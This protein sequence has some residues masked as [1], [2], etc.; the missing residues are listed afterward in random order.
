MSQRRTKR[1]WKRLVVEELSRGKLAVGLG[2]LGLDHKRG[3]QDVR[4]ESVGGKLGK[5]WPDESP[6]KEEL[7]VLQVSKNLH[8]PGMM[9][10]KAIKAELADDW[11]KLTR[12]EG[13]NP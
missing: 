6:H 11:S 5:V 4:E 7:A 13:L 12:S 1:Q 9:A 3:L 10:R 2:Q 8:L